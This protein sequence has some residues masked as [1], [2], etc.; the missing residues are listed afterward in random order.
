MAQEQYNRWSYNTFIGID[1]HKRSFSCTVRDFGTLAQRA[2]MPSNPE[3]FFH[4]LQKLNKH[5]KVVCAY[6]AGPTGF[7]LYDYLTDRQIPCYIT[8]P[9]SIP[10]P[11]NERVKTDRIDSAKLVEYLMSGQFKPIRV[12]E[13]PYRE[14]RHLVKAYDRYSAQRKSTKQRIKALLLYTHVDAALP[15]PEARWSGRYL[16]DLGNLTCSPAIRHRLDLLLEDLTYARARIARTHRLIRAFCRQ[17]A[18]IADYM[19]YL[20]SIPG[21]GFITA[22]TIL[23]RIGDPAGLVDQREFAAFLGLT[24]REGSSGDRIVKGSITH[25]GDKR[26]R[27]LLVEAAWTTIRR[28]TQLQQFYYRI[29]Q[30]HHGAHAPKIAITAV[31]RKLTQIIYRVL[32]DRRPYHP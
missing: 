7:H 24:P 1:V 21:I 2:R 29:H 15:D 9:A 16:Q 12:P 17:E 27:S 11:S 3:T 5:R 6:E 23:G 31:A 19:G 14:L 28:D 10:R 4:Y 30:R 20:Q 22:F 25:L 32:K 13:G 26:L 8:S 18:E